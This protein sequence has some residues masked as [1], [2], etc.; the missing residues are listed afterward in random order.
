MHRPTPISS[1]SSKDWRDRRIVW[2]AW[3]PVVA[4]IICVPI[5]CGQSTSSETTTGVQ[6][7][8]I[9]PTGHQTVQAIPVILPPVID[10]R[11]DEGIWQ[12]PPHNSRFTVIGR[13]NQPARRPTSVRIA[14]DAYSLYL[15]LSCPTDTSIGPPRIRHWVDDDENVGEDESCRI[16]LQPNPLPQAPYYDITINPQGVLS[17]ARRFN[18]FPIPQNGWDGPVRAAA[19]VTRGLW[20]AEIML[21]LQYV[22]IPD[23]PWKINIIRHDALADELSS[24]YPMSMIASP[25]EDRPIPTGVL[26]WPSPAKP[27]LVSPLPTRQLSIEGAE[28]SSEAWQAKEATISPS[29]RRAT[30][31]RRSLD[32]RFNTHSGSIT[33]VVPSGNF[34]GWSWLKLELSLEGKDTATLGVRLRD[35]AGH[36]RTAWFLARPGRNPVSLPME[37][38]A[39]GLQSRSIRAIEILSIAPAQIRLD[40]IR[41]EDDIVSYH[42]Q[43]NRPPQ[44]SCSKL[45]TRVDAGNS[46]GMESARP[47]ISVSVA[48]PLFNT[49]RIRRLERAGGSGAESFVFL[50]EEFAGHDLRDPVSITATLWRLGQ[51]SVAW[52]EV[53]LSQSVEEVRFGP[54]DF[55]RIA[56]SGVN[57]S[58]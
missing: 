17:D 46:A 24:L 22:G 35:A 26:Q 8:H 50:P 12:Q 2:G 15:G 45:T 1:F 31:G 20:Q 4:A 40:S 52:R 53:R 10:G 30:G 36:E 48:V 49:R 54:D 34:K 6:Q 55:P 27:F 44:Q 32:V 42:E 16:I 21:P 58:R 13:P 25:N 33:R 9:D 51:V 41:L 37:S 23:H 3:L 7:A 43:P 11:L 5:G 28:D 38:L 19:T 47:S 18:G 14:Y 56:S 29:D 39:T 57:K